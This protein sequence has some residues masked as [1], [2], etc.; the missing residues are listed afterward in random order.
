MQITLKSNYY[1]Y[2]LSR[3]IWQP[4]EIERNYRA[5]I[6]WSNFWTEK[7]L[8]FFPLFLSPSMPLVWHRLGLQLSPGDAHV[9]DHVIDL[10]VAV[11]MS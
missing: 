8:P 2:Y 5:Y 3:L 4:A 11:A 7:F 9:I 6:V 10:N 1:K